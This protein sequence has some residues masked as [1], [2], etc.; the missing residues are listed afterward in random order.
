MLQCVC[1]LI[2]LAVSVLAPWRALADVADSRYVPARALAAG[3]AGIPLVDDGAGALFYQPAM[4]AKG[5]RISIEPLNLQLY[6]NSG[7]FGTANGASLNALSIDSIAGNLR[8]NPNTRV[9]F[10]GS[11]LPSVSMPFLSFGILAQTKLLAH[12]DSAGTI[13]SK[14]LYQLI[15]AIGTGISLGH[16]ILKLGYSLQYV[17]QASGDKTAAAGTTAGGFSERIAEGHAFSHNAGMAL[18]LPY[19]HLPSFHAVVRNIGGARYSNGSLYPM[20][21]NPQG[22]PETDKMSF[23]AAIGWNEKIGGGNSLRWSIQARDFTNTKQVSPAL[24]YL[25]GLE[26]SFKDAIMLR[27]G[28]GSGYP[29]AGIGFRAKNQSDFSL[30]WYSE[31]L[32]N[33]YHGYR[34]QRFMFQYQL[35]FF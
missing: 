11:L 8:S 29:S 19:Q 5:K 7:F 25:A 16:G 24:R 26:L 1:S 17:N 20:A 12:A 31:E 32:T 9:G 13:Y 18:T 23:D 14:S 34:D 33:A 6:G 4:L 2:I 15:P 21:K 3:G 28:Y 27:G 10:G 22:V 30:S 35:R